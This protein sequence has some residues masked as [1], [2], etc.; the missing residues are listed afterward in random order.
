MISEYKKDKR[1]PTTAYGEIIAP[2]R[3]I[4]RIMNDENEIVSKNKKERL[5]I[6]LNNIT[7]N[8]DDDSIQ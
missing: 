8:Q 5:K 3:N 2:N 4:K 7:V 1:R 6:L